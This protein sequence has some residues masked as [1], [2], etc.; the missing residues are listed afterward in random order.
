MYLLL[1]RI[2]W[3]NN[4][5]FIILLYFFICLVNWIFC[6]DGVGLLDGW[7]W[8]NS[9]WVEEY[10]IVFWKILCGWVIFWFSDFLKIVFCWIMLFLVFK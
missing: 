2:I 6:G 4:W 3:F 9:M 7:L 5:I 1:L 10:L 8:V